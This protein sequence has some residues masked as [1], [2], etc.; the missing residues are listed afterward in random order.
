MWNNSKAK[1]NTEESPKAI[2]YINREDPL[3]L[4][5]RVEMM[6]KGIFIGDRQIAMICM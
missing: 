1:G 3:G 2:K 6:T 4:F 5:G